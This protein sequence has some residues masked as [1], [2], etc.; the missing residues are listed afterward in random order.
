MQQLWL[1]ETPA[2][3]LSQ[4]IERGWIMQGVVIP[5]TAV[6]MVEAK[7][8]VKKWSRGQVVF[9]VSVKRSNS[10]FK[11]QLSSQDAIE[12]GEATE[13]IGAVK[14]SRAFLQCGQAT[15]MT[16]EIS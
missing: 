12:E 5:Y 14:R 13:S 8:G 7:T 11:T 4:L 9:L 15:N 6:V 1:K 16:V 2:L 3:W 10:S